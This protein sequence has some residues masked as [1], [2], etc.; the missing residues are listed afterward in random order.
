MELGGGAAASHPLT[1]HSI[2]VHLDVTDGGAFGGVAIAEAV[3][4]HHQLI[5]S[6]VILLFDLQPGIQEIVS[7]RVKPGEVDPQVGDLQ[8]VCEGYV[9]LV[10]HGWPSRKARFGNPDFIFNWFLIYT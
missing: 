5:H 1:H 3:T 7:Q 6:V 2:R 9:H 4:A 10:R 8:Q